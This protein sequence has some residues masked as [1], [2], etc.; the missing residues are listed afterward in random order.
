MNKKPDIIPENYEFIQTKS[1][2][3]RVIRDMYGSPTSLNGKIMFDK[4]NKC[5]S[6]ADIDNLLIWGRVNLL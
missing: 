4:L 2:A 3:E 1:Q 5:K 6:I